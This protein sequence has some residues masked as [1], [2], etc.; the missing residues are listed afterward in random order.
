MNKPMVV[1]SILSTLASGAAMADLQINGFA[2][3]KAG[4]TSG[5]DK[6]LYG[7]TDEL[8]FKNESLFAIQIRS[9]LGEKLSVTAQVMGRGS[10]DFDAAFEWAFLSYQLT[11]N[12]SINAGRDDAM[13]KITGALRR[14]GVPL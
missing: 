9:D 10:N 12:M 5:S 2:S 13:Q 14:G 11:D 1:I 7:Y 4:L 8:D 3:I 6:T